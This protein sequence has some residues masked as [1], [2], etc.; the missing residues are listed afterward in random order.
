MIPRHIKDICRTC[1]KEFMKQIPNT[2]RKKLRNVRSSK[3]VN[4]SKECS[5]I[6][7]AYMKRKQ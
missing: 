6:Y 5:R 7:S 1:G 3:S 2:I 4:C